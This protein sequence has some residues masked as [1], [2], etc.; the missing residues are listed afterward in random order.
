[1]LALFYLHIDILSF[2]DRLFLPLPMRVC[3]Q[4]GVF[5]CLS[6]EL[7]KKKTLTDLIHVALVEVCSM[8]QQRGTHS[9]FGADLNH[10]AGT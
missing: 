9:L 6:A 1:M 10:W 3:F 2:G 4:S 8:A 7:P 5:V